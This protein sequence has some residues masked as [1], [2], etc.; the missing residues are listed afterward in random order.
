MRFVMVDTAEFVAR[1]KAMHGDRFDYSRVTYERMKSPATFVCGEHGEFNATPKSHLYSQ[2]GGCSHCRSA[3]VRQALRP[4]TDTFTTRARRV[5]GEQ[6]DYNQVEYVGSRNRV[7]IVCPK[8]GAFRMTPARH[9]QGRGCRKCAFERIGRERRMTFWEF[10]ERVVEVHGAD[11]YD[12]ELKDFV[13]AHSLIP[14]RCPKHGEFRQSVA[15]HLRGHGCPRCVQS[16]GEQRVRESLTALGV[17]FD[18][19]V[20]F[21]ECRDRRALPFDF[22]VPDRGLLIEYDGRQHVANSETWGGDE[23]LEET[24]R[25]DAIKDAFARERGLTLLR[26]PHWEYENVDRLLHERL[27]KVAA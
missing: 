25:H 14:I 18:E 1:A 12:Y 24:K 8:H 3:I 21:E 15:A 20:R 6:Y 16:K 2:S 4:T 19:Q 11:T 13:N 7:T 26:I 17:P 27:A 9:L 5:H 23:K 22:F 10:V